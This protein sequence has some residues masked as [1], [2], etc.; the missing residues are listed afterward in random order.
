MS[1]K[2][3]FAQD[4]NVSGGGYAK[5][6]QSVRTAEY[7]DFNGVADFYGLTGAAGKNQHRRPAGHMHGKNKPY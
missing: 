5:A 2:K 6:N 7:A 3:F 4:E 1:E